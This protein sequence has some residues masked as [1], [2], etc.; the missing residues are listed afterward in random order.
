M[1]RVYIKQVS[2][3]EPAAAIHYIYDLPVRP[4]ELLELHSVCCYWS[5]IANTEEIHFFIEEGGRKTFLA[6]EVSN[7]TGGHPRW[8]GKV[9]IGEGCRVGAY[10]PDSATND[11][12]YLDIFGVIHTLSEW[13]SKA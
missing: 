4:G 11:V 2:M 1:Q 12:I 3:T 5:A 10:C 13:K 9:F 7:D 8:K 6:E